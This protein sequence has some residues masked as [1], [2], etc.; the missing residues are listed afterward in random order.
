LEGLMEDINKIF[1]DRDKEILESTGIDIKRETRTGTFIQ[2]DHS[3]VSCNIRQDGIEILPTK[4]AL[5]K[6]D[7]LKDLKFKSFKGNVDDFLKQADD[8]VSN[9]YFIYA[10]KGVKT[11]YP[12]QACLYISNDN[13]EQYVHNF[14]IAEEGAEL[15]I[16]SG[17]ATSHKVSS[18]LHVG[19][20]EFFVKKNAKI[21]FTMIH[22]WGDNVTV[23]PKSAAIVEDN[24][25]FISNY[26]SFDKVK[27]LKMYPTVYL[28]GKNSIGRFNSIVF[29]PE[30]SHI[31]LGSRCVLNG[32]GS[33]A[34]IVSRTVSAG[35]DIIARGHLVG[36][37]KGIKAH[38]ECNGLLLKDKGLIHAVPELEAHLNDVDMSHE[39]AVGK[40]AEEEIEYLMS[41]GLTEEEATSAIVRGFL[42]VKIEGLPERLEKQIEFS[43]NELNDKF[44]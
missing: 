20:S 13:V 3:V 17:C 26:I 37:A 24:G 30:G 34:E 11:K 42:N 1:D 25:V 21:S 35:G 28:N 6:Y 31:D 19:I 14:I 27:F 33:K 12:V 29:G 22:K 18:A 15:N 4:E 23:T 40:I 16:I 7:W 32:E 2:S 43:L 39:A 5:K 36:A 38:L 9:G 8:K 41:R 44:F 10:K